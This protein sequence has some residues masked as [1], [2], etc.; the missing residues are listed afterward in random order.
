[1]ALIRSIR[2]I[3]SRFVASILRNFPFNLI[4]LSIQFFESSRNLV[5]VK[6]LLLSIVTC[7]RWY[8]LIQTS[9]RKWSKYHLP[10]ET[11][12]TNSVTLVEGVKK[13]LSEIENDGKLREREI[14]STIN[15]RFQFDHSL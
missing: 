6:I 10:N 15:N 2:S 14:T 7:I 1:M 4:Q 13:S 3:R 5:F 8:N 12:R 9:C 11:R